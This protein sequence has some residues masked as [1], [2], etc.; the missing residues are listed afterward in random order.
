MS[1]KLEFTSEDMERWADQEVRKVLKGLLRNLT[2]VRTQRGAAS[3]TLPDGRIA[4]LKRQGE[5]EGLNIAIAAVR[6]RIR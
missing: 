3:F 4:Q 2:D 1:E 6:R 5:I